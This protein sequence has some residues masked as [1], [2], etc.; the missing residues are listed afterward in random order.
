[1]SVIYSLFVLLVS[2]SSTDVSGPLSIST[3]PTFAPATRMLLG[4]VKVVYILYYDFKY[5]YIYSHTAPIYSRSNNN[6]LF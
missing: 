2:V 4:V 3:K 6:R 1:M 5:I